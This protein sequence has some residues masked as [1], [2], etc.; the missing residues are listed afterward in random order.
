MVVV[1]HFNDLADGLGE[2]LDASDFFRRIAE[3]NPT[4]LVVMLAGWG[5]NEGEE[6]ARNMAALESAQEILS[7]KQVPFPVFFTFETEELLNWYGMLANKEERAISELVISVKPQSYKTTVVED[8]NMDVFYGIESS[9][10]NSGRPVV[11]ISTS[12]DA[13]GAAPGLP[14]GVETSLSPL[15]GILYMSRVFGKQFTQ[16]VQTRFDLMFILTPGGSL[17]YEASSK[18]VDYIQGTLKSKISLVICLDQLVDSRRPW[19]EGQSLYIY[20]SAQSQQSS[21]RDSFVYNLKKLVGEDSFVK[22]AVEV[23]L[24]AGDQQSPRADLTP[25]EP[26]EHVAYAKKGIAALTVTVAPMENV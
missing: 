3:S 2:K 12:Y 15:L 8:L 24:F 18:F 14:S 26:L 9:S 17:G 16:T 13:F 7:T 19:D 5:E 25:F 10:E 1:I 4:G 6:Y 11:A 23:G 21:I 20:D 22:E